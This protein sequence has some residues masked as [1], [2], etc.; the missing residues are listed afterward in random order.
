[1][2]L[3]MAAA[4]ACSDDSTNTT[5]QGRRVDAATAQAALTE[6]TTNV[7]TT[8]G[9]V[10]TSG[11]GENTVA[12]NCAGG[13]LANVVGHV[14]VVPVPLMVDVNV[15]I[16]YAGCTS[17]SGTKLSGNIDFSQ[18]VQAGS[19]PVLVQTLY[20]GDVTFTGNIEASCIVDLNVLVDE[21]GKLVQVAGSFCGQDAAAL[22][23]Q[24]TPRWSR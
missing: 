12:L 24:I 23:L 4:A 10:N 15:G 1:M 8:V 18:K 13:G 16:D 7:D 2:A 3:C 11:T 9:G 20:Q 14:N 22:N 19:L 5:S 21:A 17:N 6:L